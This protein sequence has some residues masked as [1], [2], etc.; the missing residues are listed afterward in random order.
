MEIFYWVTLLILLYT[1]AGYPFWLVILSRLRPQKLKKKDI[2]PSV[3]VL[4]TVYNEERVIEKRI[5]NLLEADYP[6]DLLYILIA[7]DGSTDKTNSIVASMAKEENRIRLFTNEKEGPSSTQN[8][9]IPH[10]R[11]EI[12][13]LT[14][15]DTTYKRDTIKNLIKVFADPRVGCVSGR[16]VLMNVDGSISKSQG[17]YWRYE[18]FLRKL[19]SK[20]G[21]LHTASGQIMAFRKSLFK[22][23]KARYGDDCIIPLD[24]ISQGYKVVHEDSA[25]AYDSFPSTARGEFNAR[26][27]MT[28]KNITC[29]LSKFELLNPLKFPLL[30]H[31]ILFH[32]VF[33]WLTPYFMIA[34]FVTNLFLFN[35]GSFYK[36][37]FNFQILFYLIGLVGFIGERNN[38]SV[39]AASQVFSFILANV[40]FFLG[41]LK[42]ILGKKITYY[43]NI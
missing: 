11:G 39:P 12:I 31:S 28:L 5:K 18:I 1:W 29:T 30:S 41:V 21:L 37:T 8:K 16:L 42:A 3:T 43:M 38:F 23:F 24:I 19:E 14:D 32:K 15:A 36:V 26:V 20:L 13:V 34:L 35:E 33:R 4:L 27:R 25:I 10:A 22:P 7:S 9:A 6:R 2:C 17:F 40:G